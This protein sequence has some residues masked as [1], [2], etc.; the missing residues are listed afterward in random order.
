ML[1]ILSVGFPL[2]LVGR[3]TAGGAEQ[4][5]AQLDAGIV[6]A[7]YRSIV[8]APKGSRVRGTLVPLPP[9]SGVLDDAARDA[10]QAACRRAIADVLQRQSVDLVHLHGIDFASYLPAP[11]PPVLV[12]LHLPLTWYSP[13]ALRPERPNTWLHCVSAS[14]WADAPA[15]L[16]LLPTVSNGVD[17]DA[18]AAR[19]ANRGFVLGLGRIC[20]EKGFHIALDA[21]K[22]AGLPMLLGGQIF[23]YAEHE[24]YFAE[25]IVPRL[26]ARRRF[27]G[28]VGFA[29]KRR[30]LSAARCVAVPSLVA[31]TGSLVAMEAL[32]CGTPVV[33]IP[34]GA[35][36]D[37]IEDGVTGFLVRD[38]REMAKA[39]LAAG[40][41]D[42]EACR[43]SARSRF[44]AQR[45]V[46]RYLSLYRELTCAQRSA[47]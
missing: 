28:L 3:D 19:H 31:E 40:D 18:L 45:T 30:L 1:T 13:H 8:V 9:T 23:R 21:A 16:R 2:A 11:G 5:L 25:Q 17:S 7:G 35:L 14:Q 29:R 44:S 10:A 22:A 24:A 4:V 27:I 6:Q 39:M 20:P 43:A 34:N 26:D 47:A 41:L 33:A 15:D 42:P 32:A 36:A 37:L 12:T 38:V 46:D